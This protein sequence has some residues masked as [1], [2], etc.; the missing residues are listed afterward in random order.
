MLEYAAWRLLRLLFTIW[1]IVSIVF[2][3]TRLTGDAIN[4]LMPE[5]LDAAS[6]AQLA[7]YLG[8]DR[9]IPEQYL[10][11]WRSLL[12][13]NP[14]LSLFQ[15]RSVLEIFSERWLQSAALLLSTM[16]VTVLVGVPFGILAAIWRQR[17]SGKVVLF[18]A[19]LAYTIPNFVL[20]ILLLVTFSGTL[21]LLPSTG[22]ST[23]A[24]YVMPTLALAAYFI[25]SLVRYTRNAMLDV[26]SQDYMRTARAKGLSE[27]SVI[28]RHGLR[29]ALIPVITVLGLQVTTLVSGA[30]V[31]ETVF[32]WNGI[33]D[34]LVN[35]T[36]FRD[37][38][39]LEFGVIVVA[40]GV[41][42]VNVLIDLAYVAI[43]PRV[44]LSGER[45]S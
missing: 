43:D 45:A 25:A 10:L 12:E 33:G 39:V 1:A 8:L 28:L 42:A 44:K 3:A 18:T 22:S 9:P 38:P 4:F 24:H 15:R 21:H 6:R 13:G 35:A 20:A 37:Y 30:V 23:L 19:F 2:V 16:T 17:L 29:N 34:L 7:S 26:L 36:L 14:G 32:A 41:I 11:Y 27:R 5:G 31:I 40:S